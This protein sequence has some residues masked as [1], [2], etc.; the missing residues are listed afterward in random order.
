[1]YSALIIVSTAINLQPYSWDDLTSQ[2]LD[3]CK[4]PVFPTNNVAV[5]SKQNQTTTK[6]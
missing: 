2:P 3:W 1:M 4:N 5:T 6:L